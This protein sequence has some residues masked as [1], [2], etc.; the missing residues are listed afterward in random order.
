VTVV[1]SGDVSTLHPFPR[2]DSSWLFS[3]MPVLVAA[4][5][6]ALVACTLISWALTPRLCCVVLC[7]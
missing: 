7:R 4:R 2:L 3:A 1:I 5:Y 6:E